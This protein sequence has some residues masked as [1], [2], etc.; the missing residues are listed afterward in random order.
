MNLTYK[1][2]TSLNLVIWNYCSNLVAI[3]LFFCQKGPQQIGL[4]KQHHST[5][6]PINLLSICYHVDFA[7]FVFLGLALQRNSGLWP[8][9]RSK[10]SRM[11][12][13]ALWKYRA[14]NSNI[15]IYTAGKVR[16][17]RCNSGNQDKWCRF[18]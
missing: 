5:Q 4:I 10:L 12:Y 3:E 18:Y 15:R 14:S 1:H 9:G 11:I 7:C 13:T 16:K 2:L 17:G 8:D 6:R